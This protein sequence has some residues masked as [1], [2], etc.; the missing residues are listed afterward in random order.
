MLPLGVSRD[1]RRGGS[2]Q[3]VPVGAVSLYQGPNVQRMD[4]DQGNKRGYRI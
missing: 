4:A 2:L 3:T 1:A